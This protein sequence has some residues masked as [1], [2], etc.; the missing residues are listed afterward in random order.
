MT[1]TL[2]P[3]SRVSLRAMALRRRFPDP[4]YA[5][6]ARCGWGPRA[7]AKQVSGPHGLR[8]EARRLAP[9]AMGAMVRRGGVVLCQ[10]CATGHRTEVHHPVGRS[11]SPGWLCEVDVRI[12]RLVHFFSGW[13]RFSPGLA[14]QLPSWLRTASGASP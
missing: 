5:A 2:S 12:H 4:E 9:Q 11:H 1:A 8:R 10:A 7:L 6:C 13:A 14:A 3:A